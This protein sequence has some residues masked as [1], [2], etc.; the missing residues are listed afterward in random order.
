MVDKTRKCSIEQE[1]GEKRKRANKKEHH[2]PTILFTYRQLFFA[3]TV[4]IYIRN[5]IYIFTKVHWLSTFLKNKN[6][7]FCWS[8]K[9]YVTFE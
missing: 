1:R 3:K 4:Q 6:D 9:Y 2:L 5:E 7:S 8:L